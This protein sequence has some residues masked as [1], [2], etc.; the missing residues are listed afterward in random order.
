MEPDDPQVVRQRKSPTMHL[1]TH[2]AVVLQTMS[3]RARCSEA[4]QTLTQSLK[5]NC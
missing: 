3:S 2:E 4:V 5:A 1:Q